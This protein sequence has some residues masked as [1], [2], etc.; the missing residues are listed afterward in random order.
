M[1]FIKGLL[2]NALIN[3]IYFNNTNPYLINTKYYFQLNF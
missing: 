1:H 2:Y 3:W